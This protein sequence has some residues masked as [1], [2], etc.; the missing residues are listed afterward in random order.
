MIKS[1][2][3]CIV[4]ILL[5]LTGCAIN[6]NCNVETNNRSEVADHPIQH[7]LINYARKYYG[8]NAT[9]SN[10]G[11]VQCILLKIADCKS[12][13]SCEYLFIRDG[14]TDE[15]T[16]D[17]YQVN[18]ENPNWP[19]SCQLDKQ[20]IKELFSS[21]S[22]CELKH[23]GIQSAG[24]VEIEDTKEWIG[25]GYPFFYFEH[26]MPFI[27][28]LKN[29]EHIEFSVI[30]MTMTEFY[31]ETNMTEHH[32]KNIRSLSIYAHD[33]GFPIYISLAGVRFID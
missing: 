11:N 22:F 26:L 3:N 17:Y 2:F 4:I 19:S 13:L 27:S 33:D 6:Q 5:I 23:W 7:I 10:K 9:I 12:A 1:V 14:R 32:G 31:L 21:E 16:L 30:P 8:A 15:C 18:N 28:Q 25:T 24:L 29:C 20:V